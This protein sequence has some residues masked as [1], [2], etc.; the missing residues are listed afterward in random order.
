MRFLVKA[1]IPIEAG[2]AMIRDPHFPKQIEEI[3]ADIK[4]E[5]V[6]FTLDGGQR[7]IYLVSSTW[8]RAQRC[9]L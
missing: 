5:A 8:R 6:Y 3:L 7:T 9:P 1:E 4:P 2:N